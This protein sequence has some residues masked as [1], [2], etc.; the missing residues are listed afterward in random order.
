[1]GAKRFLKKTGRK[2]SANDFETIRAPRENK[3]KELVRRNV[4]AE[5]IDVKSLVAQDGFGIYHAVLPP[6]TRNFMPPKHDLILDDVDEYVVIL[7]SYTRN[8]MPP[9]HDLIL[10]DVD[11]YVVSESVT[12]VPAVATNKA[13]TSESKPKSSSEPHIEDWISD[14]EDENETKSKPINTAYLRPTVNSARPLSNVFNRAHSHVRCPFKKFTAN[15]NNNF[16]EKVNTVRGNITTAGP[17]AVV[18]DDKGN[19]SNPQVELYEK[20]VIDNGCSRHMTGNISYLFEYKEID[21]GYVAFA[22][23]P[24]G[25]KIIGKGKISTGGLARLF[26]NATLDES[27]L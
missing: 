8:F 13:K 26:E 3:N 6:Y 17:R 21:G 12:S 25:G 20:G 23:D 4:T 1:M 19:K 22:G 11:E 2:V 14:S 16:N 24:K 5:T 9:K 18:S 27:N 10:D 15:K 7:P